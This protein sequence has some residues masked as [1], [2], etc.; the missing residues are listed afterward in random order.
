M[1]LNP[2]TPPPQALKEALS[3]SEVEKDRAAVRAF[4]RVLEKMSTSMHKSYTQEKWEGYQPPA[5]SYT[6][7]E[8]ATFVTMISDILD[9]KDAVNGLIEMV[10]E[11]TAPHK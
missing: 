2:P 4:V 9:E 1:D 11:G 8:Q 5:G 6:A 3:Q 7:D 10:D